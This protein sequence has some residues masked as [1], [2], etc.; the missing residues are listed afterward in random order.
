MTAVLILI[1][2][3]SRVLT[4]NLNYQATASV[5]IDTPQPQVYTQIANLENWARWSPFVPTNAGQT[6]V[7]AGEQGQS[8]TWNDPRGGVSV[9]TLDDIDALD[10]TV[11]HSMTSK[12]FP[13]LSG[14]LQAQ[15]SGQAQPSGPSTQVQWT[16]RGTLPDTL[17]Y[18]FASA[19]FT[20]GLTNELQQ[21][22]GRL[23]AVCERDMQMQSESQSAS[24][25]A[26]NTET[27]Q[28]PQ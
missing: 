5:I 3:L 11:Q 21:S 14:T 2:F 10:G 9:L 23:K 28:K 4:A 24:D 8:I 6:Q 20:E 17:F 26:A 27:I 7:Q 12:L 18:R 25:A 15:S 1:F 13:Q 16:M 22:L 19:S